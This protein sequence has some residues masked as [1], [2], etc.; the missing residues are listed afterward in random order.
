MASRPTT[1]TRC[2]ISSPWRNSPT[3]WADAAPR[4][5]SSCRRMPPCVVALGAPPRPPVLR[6]RG[7]H[8]VPLLSSHEV[9]GRG[10]PA[11]QGGLLTFSA[12]PRRCLLYTSDAADDLTRVDLGG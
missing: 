2:W 6:P 11:P 9:G 10:A 12:S 1:T 3:K 7:R 4:P 5:W 8:A